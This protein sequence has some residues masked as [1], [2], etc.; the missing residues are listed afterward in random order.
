MISTIL[1]VLA[2]LFVGFVLGFLFTLATSPLIIS[3]IHLVKEGNFAVVYAT[4]AGRNVMLMR[5]VAECSFSHTITPLGIS[6]AYKRDTGTHSYLK[7]LEDQI[8]SL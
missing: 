2:A 3:S 5:E 4:I 8:E 7:K 6:M 1:I